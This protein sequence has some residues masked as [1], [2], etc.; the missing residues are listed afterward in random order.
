MA[1][2]VEFSDRTFALA[3]AS[4]GAA[5]L[6]WAATARSIGD[7][8]SRKTSTST[9]RSRI[10]TTSLSGRAVAT[11]A[12]IS[13]GVSPLILMAISHVRG[14][15]L[16]TPRLLVDNLVQKDV[17]T[18]TQDQQKYTEKFKNPPNAQLVGRQTN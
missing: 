2:A 3:A 13:S 14:S 6:S 12:S 11:S 18:H 4:I 5:T 8:T 15:T 16:L 10:E 9:L 7:A 1:P 17:P